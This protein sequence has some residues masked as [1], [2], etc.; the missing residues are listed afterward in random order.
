MLVTSF[1]APVLY[2]LYT[3]DTL[4][5]TGTHLFLF[6]DDTCIYLTEKQEHHV[7]CKLQHGLTTVKPWYERWNMKVNEGKAQEINFS[8]R[9]GVAK[10]VLQLNCPFVYNVKCL[11]VT[12]NRR[13]TWRLCIGRTAAKALG[14]YI[15]TY[16]LFKC[17]H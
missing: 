11:G 12:F 5:A 9:L 4:T 7:P 16:S 15:S 8:R 1:L 13:M 6:E 3:N 17:E 2:S 10:N 14:M